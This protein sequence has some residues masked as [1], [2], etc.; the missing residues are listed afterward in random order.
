MRVLEQQNGRAARLAGGAALLAL[1]SALGS[2]SASAQTPSAQ[3]PA[4]QPPAALN[5]NLA[6]ASPFQD[7]DLVYLEA[8]ELVNDEDAGV[9][10]ARGSVEGRYGDRTL[11]A[12]TVVYNLESGEIFAEGDV[13]IIDATGGSQFADKIELTG[14]L[15]S[16]TATNFTLRT[17]D[18][19]LTAAA[20]AVRNDDGSIALYNAYYTACETCESDPDPTWRLRAGSVRQ[21]LDRKAII[22]NDAVLEVLGI[23]VFYTPY[24]SHPDPSAERASGLLTPSFGSSG[25][26]GAF[27]F[28]PYYVAVDPY[29]DLTVTPRIYSGINP[30]LEVEGRRNFATGSVNLQTSLTYASLFDNEGD[31]IRDVDQ[32]VFAE[33]AQTG[34]RLRSHTFLDGRFNPSRD[35]TWGFGVE[36]ASDSTYLLRNDFDRNPNTRGLFDSDSLR[37][38]SQAYVVGQGESYRFSASAFGFQSARGNIIKIEDDTVN[39]GLLILLEEDNGT[40]PIVHPRVDYTQFVDVGGTRLELFGNAISLSRQKGTDYARGTLGARWSETVIAPGGLEVK[41]FAMGRFDQYRLD[42]DLRQSAELDPRFPL[43]DPSAPLADDG[44]RT[45]SRTLGLGGVDVRYPFLRP[46]GEGGVDIVVEPRAQLTYSTG[47]GKLEN[48]TATDAF[49][50]EA[51]LLQDSLATDLDPTLL[52]DAN[53]SSGYDFWQAGTRVDAGTS[54]RA[55]W[56]GGDGG[57]RSVSAFV[58]KSWADVREGEFDL[59]SGLRGDSSDIVGEISTEFGRTLRTR[60]RVRYDDETQEFR[61]IDAEAVVGWR[62]LEAGGRYFRVQGPS[63]ADQDPTLPT[64][65]GTGT[66]RW[67]IADNWTTGY[68]LLYDFSNDE[69]RQ[70]VVGL[71]YSDSCT[72]VEL[73]YTKF[74]SGRNSLRDNDSISVRV[75]LLTLGSTD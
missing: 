16:G 30:I 4:A 2:L 3:A 5:P 19:G 12:D 40:L 44:T 23:P 45:F 73:L 8:D 32:F 18:G 50:A 26:K 55:S 53:K 15:Q 66:V 56:T 75:S 51:S 41:P 72:A 60:T 34:R 11:R 10:T 20:L 63:V 42:P 64:E 70:Q 61:R 29:T 36:L 13:T 43:I 71:T 46:G 35:W 62:D 24:L 33:N 49:G 57:N 54:V 65:A 47:D 48:F 6:A 59:A 74:G 1:A 37:L 22:Y 14:E 25:D 21:D 17:P 9:L 39:N 58:G 28:L 38:I 27:V 52:W 7:P 68:Q 67:K 31:A 69:I